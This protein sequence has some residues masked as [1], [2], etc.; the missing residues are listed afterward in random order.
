[1]NGI[2]SIQNVV[3][4]YNKTKQ[5]KQAMVERALQSTSLAM[6]HIDEFIQV[7]GFELFNVLPFKVMWNSF[8]Q[9]I[10]IYITDDLVEIFGYTGDIR[11]QRGHIAKHVK[12][13]G[14]PV[15][16]LSN[17]AYNEFLCSDLTTQDSQ[18]EGAVLINEMYPPVE[19][20][21]GSGRTKHTLIMPRELKKLL[22]NVNTLTGKRVCEYM[23]RLDE[24]FEL[25]LLYQKTRET[26]LR[27]LTDQYFK[28]E[29]LRHE[30]T[31]QCFKDAERQRIE[32][33]ERHERESM[34]AKERHDETME[35]LN[36]VSYQLNTAV[37]ER[38]PRTSDSTKH[39]SF[40]LARLNNKGDPVVKYYAVRNQVSS[41]KTT[42]RRLKTKYPDMQVLVE[43][44]YQPN[45]KNL[46]N[47]MKEYLMVKEKKI[48]VRVNHVLLTNGY[49]EEELVAD[50]LLLDESKREVEEIVV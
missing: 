35:V 23:V 16:R 17:K 21:H 42:L 46:F 1:M 14:I 2:V 34:E 32:E 36:D 47:L 33:K 43:I 29:K 20:T 38:A 12:N 41:I 30:Q 3:D 49:T 11:V 48:Q 25:Y 50:I 6:L 37:E 8:R 7:T 10:P 22:M 28:D 39:E 31:M 4:L 44:G 26:R 9:D 18:E 45:S 5:A 15:I 24:L 27:D 40:V 13:Y 19:K